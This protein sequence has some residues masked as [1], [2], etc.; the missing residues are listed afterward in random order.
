M[1]ADGKRQPAR[2]LTRRQRPREECAV[3]ADGI[4]SESRWRC[5]PIIRV[6]FDPMLIFL[7]LPPASDTRQLH[8]TRTDICQCDIGCDNVEQARCDDHPQNGK[9]SISEILR[10]NC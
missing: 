7:A 5:T 8:E 10:A 1:L 2:T 6:N 4:T 3:L 9:Q